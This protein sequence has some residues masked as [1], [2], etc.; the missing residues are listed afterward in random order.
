MTSGCQECF[1]SDLQQAIETHLKG[2]PLRIPRTGMRAVHI[3][4]GQRLLLPFLC[5]DLVLCKESPA[6]A[7]QSPELL[8]GELV[9]VSIATDMPTQGGKL[10][11]QAFFSSH[12]C[13][14]VL[15][16]SSYTRIATPAAAEAEIG[17]ITLNNSQGL[18]QY[19]S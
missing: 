10:T 8:L 7:I 19:I 13:N 9:H 6:L 3:D 11:T 15:T 1:C 5:A 18:C 17:V 2:Q 12:W 4:Q 16:E 14:T